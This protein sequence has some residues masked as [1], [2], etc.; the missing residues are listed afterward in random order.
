MAA[1]SADAPK[2]LTEN[3]QETWEGLD[4][5][6]QVNGAVFMAHKRKK[7]VK[8]NDLETKPA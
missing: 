8:R 3:V 5:L 1:G 2:D 6:P 4:L 7:L